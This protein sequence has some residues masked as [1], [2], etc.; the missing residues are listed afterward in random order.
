MWGDKSNKKPVAAAIP[1]QPIHT[2]AKPNLESVR[3]KNTAVIGRTVLLQGTLKSDEEVLILGT[4][5]GE[6]EL[7]NNN[8]TVGRS[9]RVQANILAKSIQIEGEVVGDIYAHQVNILK[10]GSISG[11]I[12]APRV[13]LEDGAKFK[14]SVDMDSQLVEE[15]LG[16][17]EEKA[18]EQKT[19]LVSI[20]KA[21]EAQKIV[22]REHAAVT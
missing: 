19:V 10:T 5:I 3:P 8:L 14:G 13:M 6:I 2:N 9:G 21:H 12:M 17:P 18:L 15:K 11:N 1:E 7:K 16:Q 22:S 20:N 4:V